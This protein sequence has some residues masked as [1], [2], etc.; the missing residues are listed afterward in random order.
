MKVLVA[1][2]S[3]QLGQALVHQLGERL[4]W[5]GGRDALDVADAGAVS[6]RLAAERPDVVVNASAYNKVDA[7]QDDPE[8]AFRVNAVGPLILARACAEVGA[9]FVHVSTDYVFD[10]T[11]ATPYLEDDP[12][13]PRSV[14]GLSK[15]AGELNVS[16]LGG[17]FLIVRT[18]GVLGA[19]GSR[20]KGGS[21]VERILQKARRGESL[22]V[23][24]DQVFAPTYAP[25][26][27][28]ALVALVEA[29][30]QGLVHVT[31]AGSCTWH[32]LARAALREAR[33]SI[34]VEPISS[35]ALGLQ[36]PR[37]AYSVLSTERY[38]S[39]GCPPLRPWGEAL[40]ELVTRLGV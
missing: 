5:S 1:G 30:T 9:R 6:A 20:A 22:R 21:F 34:E 2:A 33:L 24:N 18:S 13:R 38:L 3:G 4:G 17:P 16:S 28:A 40:R 12:P 32:E 31:N 15:R 27:A 26:L 8:S 23:V 10:G 25:D 36:A 7:A 37:P 19:G 35:A 11:K 14:Y 29:G 39:L